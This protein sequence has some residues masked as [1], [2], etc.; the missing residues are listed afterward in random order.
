VLVSTLTV[1]NGLH[2]TEGGNQPGTSLGP[3]DK[4]G[5]WD[6]H[7]SSSAPER[8]ILHSTEPVALL[9]KL[10]LLVDGIPPADPTGCASRWPNKD[11]AR[12]GEPSYDKFVE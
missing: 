11:G 8:E 4:D 3:P 2:P 10:Q 7:C 5:V 6:A 1:L 12:H 9:K